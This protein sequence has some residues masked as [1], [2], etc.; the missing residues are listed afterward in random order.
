M[1]GRLLGPA[2]HRGYPGPVDRG[3]SGTGLVGDDL[4]LVAHDDR[5]GKPLLPQRQLGT[6]LAAGLLAELMLGGSIC[7]RSDTAVVTGR[8]LPPGRG[9]RAVLL[10]L[11][12]AEPGPLPV[13]TG[14]G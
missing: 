7:L 8:T 11:I 1:S 6:G 4:W 2:G 14:C 9:G 5:S 3:L 12:A 13:R 10:Q